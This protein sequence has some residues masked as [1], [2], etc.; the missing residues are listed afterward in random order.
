MK[1]R[2]HVFSQSRRVPGR[3]NRRVP[4]NCSIN[5]EFA[6]RELTHSELS[7]VCG[8][9]RL[10]DSFRQTYRRQYWGNANL[11]RSAI[12]RGIAFRSLGPAAIAAQGGW[13]VGSAIYKS[14]CGTDRRCHRRLCP[15]TED[16]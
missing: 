12:I 10:T 14:V 9:S 1:W 13:R 11:S 8:G 7:Q 5:R 15:T 6:M 4:V 16:A 2:L 3:G